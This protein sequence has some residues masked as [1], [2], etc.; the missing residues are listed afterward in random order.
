MNLPG[1]SAATLPALGRVVT[2]CQVFRFPHVC[3]VRI[4]QDDDLRRPKAADRTGSPLGELAPEAS[5]GGG[6][7]TG[8]W[9]LQWKTDRNDR[10]F[11]SILPSHRFAVFPR[12]SLPSTA[13]LIISRDVLAISLISAMYDR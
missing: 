1:R 4:V 9:K 6:V 13:Y 2:D 7:R 10:F 5:E 11:E 8:N 12:E 3:L